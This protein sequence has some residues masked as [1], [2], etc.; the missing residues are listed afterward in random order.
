MDYALIVHILE[1]GYHLFPVVC[2]LFL[3]KTHFRPKITEEAL[4]TVLEDK[5]YVLRVIEKTV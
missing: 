3:R 2:S 4:G 5:V 1:G